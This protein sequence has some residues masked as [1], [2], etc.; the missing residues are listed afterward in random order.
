MFIF[1]VYEMR[2]FVVMV[3]VRWT[4]ARSPTLHLPTHRRY[5]IRKLAFGDPTWRAFTLP[6][7]CSQIFSRHHKSQRSVFLQYSNTT[8]NVLNMRT[9]NFAKFNTSA[10]M[11]ALEPPDDTRICDCCRVTR[12][13]LRFA[14]SVLL[15]ARRFHLRKTLHGSAC[16]SCY[17]EYSVRVFVYKTKGLLHLS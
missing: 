6:F 10:I 16:I 14:P 13:S 8:R 15:S 2:R 5:R 17:Q 4:D 1:T 12:G 9:L 7:I 11:G 3:L